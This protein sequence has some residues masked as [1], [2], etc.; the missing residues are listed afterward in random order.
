[1]LVLDGSMGEGGGQILRSALSL[2]LL[3]RRPITIENIRAGRSKPG[4]RPQHRQCV[5]AAARISNAEHR[6]ADVGSR[7]LVFSPGPVTHGAY[8]FDIGTAGSTS[9]VLQT[10][11]LPLSQGDGLSEIRITGGTHVPMSPP[12]DFLHHCWA[13][14]MDAIGL[15][16]AVQLV[17]PGYYPPG[18]GEIRATVR[19]PARVCALDRVERGRLQRVHGTSAVSRL[20]RPIAQRQRN[21]ARRRLTELGVPVTID[22]VETDAPSPG[23]YVVLCAEFD[24]AWAVFSSLGQR[25]KP[26]ER[27]AQEACAELLEHVRTPG[28]VDPRS[29][30]QIVLPLALAQGV[31]RYSTSKVTSHLLT[32]VEVVRA[33]VETPIQVDG[34][35]G[36]PG[37]VTIGEG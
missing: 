17:R 18:G 13:R 28:A 30:D 26:A 21:A 27:V 25:G 37:T 20:P 15:D 4:L 33:M 23:T 12:F 8:R 22:V 11:A 1:M 24:H 6:G 16:V 3:T 10:L 32:N 36:Q 9:L 31:S 2:S 7:S 14:W 29:A 19:A 34:P 35:V 5:L